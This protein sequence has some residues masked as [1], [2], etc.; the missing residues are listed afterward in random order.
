MA[1]AKYLVD[2]SA[3][4]RLRHQIVSDRLQPLLDAGLV[5]T[6]GVLNLEALYSARS[7]GEYEN[8]LRFRNS[9]FEYVDADEEVWQRAQNV[10]RTLAEASQHRAVKLPDLVIA[11]VAEHHRLVLLHYDSDFDH[12]AAVTGQAAEWVVARGAVP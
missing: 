3:L 7:H 11:A 9:I 12:V 4:N 2:T 10:Q 5:A 6:C 1:V 8:L